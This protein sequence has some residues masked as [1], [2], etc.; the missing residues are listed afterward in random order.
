MSVLFNFT[1]ILTITETISGYAHFWDFV[2][3]RK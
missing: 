1:D 2:E 3:T